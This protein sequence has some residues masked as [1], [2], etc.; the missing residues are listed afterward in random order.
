MLHV[1]FRLT[2]LATIGLS[3]ASATMGLSPASAT[4]GLTPA[5]ATMRLT[6]ASATMGLTPATTMGLTPAATVGLTPATTLGW[7]AVASRTSLPRVSAPPTA[8]S[9]SR[10]WSLLAEAHVT[11]CGHKENQ[12]PA[13]YMAFHHDD[14]CLW[15]L[16]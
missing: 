7:V 3:P 10:L 11:P 14:L 6:P 12:D 16:S 1:G 8:A 2:G 5:S 4:M 13:A 9:S 15:W